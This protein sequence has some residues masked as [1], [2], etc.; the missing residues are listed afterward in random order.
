MR[1]GS[2]DG[3]HRLLLRCRER[4]VCHDVLC[5]R[6]RVGCT[7]ASNVL[8]VRGRHRHPSRTQWSAGV[9]P[10]GPGAS[11]PTGGG[12]RDRDRDRWANSQGRCSREVPLTRYPRAPFE[13]PGLAR[14]RCGR[15]GAVGFSP[16]GRGFDAAR[17]SFGACVARES[18]GFGTLIAS[19]RRAKAHRSTG[20]IERFVP[21][22]SRA[23]SGGQLR[24]CAGIIRNSPRPLRGRRFRSH[25]SGGGALRALP[26]AHLRNACRRSSSRAVRTREGADNRSPTTDNRQP[27][28]DNQVERE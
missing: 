13:R 3:F 20:V 5:V 4:S 18:P 11:R 26:P 7:L 28:T 14:Q 6:S 2:E 9:P 19:A 21:L 25:S 23:A 24:V 16:P 1:P 15:C 27:T 22:P 17:G 8:P 10:A 12:A